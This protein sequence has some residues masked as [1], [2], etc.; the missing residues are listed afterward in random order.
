MLLL[1]KITHY[2]A[3]DSGWLYGQSSGL[4]Y[5]KGYILMKERL[6]VDRLKL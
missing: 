1:M 3:R 2:W 6:V 4:G 5:L